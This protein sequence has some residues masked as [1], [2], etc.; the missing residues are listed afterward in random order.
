MNVTIFGA[1]GRT[2]QQLVQQ[3]LDKGHKV[4]AY[5][6]RENALNIQHDGLRIITGTLDNTERLGESIRG[7]D[8]CL[9]ALGG[10]SLTKHSGEIIAGIGRIVET[11]ERQGVKRLI[12]LSSIGAGESRQFL[13]QP[14]RFLVADL[15]LRIPLADHNANE[16]RIAGSSLDWTIVWPGGLT[17]GP[18]SDNLK[19]GSNRITIKGNATISRASLASFM[20]AQADNPGYICKSVWLQE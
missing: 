15:L 12:Y 7:A 11:M 6:R 2:G 8:A 3:A 14:V 13:P 18:R 1:S 17:D 9:S 20:L 4:T 5:V 19:H 10:N 16:K